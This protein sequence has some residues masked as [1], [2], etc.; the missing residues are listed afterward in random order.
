VTSNVDF[1]IHHAGLAWAEATSEG[2]AWLERLPGLVA[3]CAERWSL[4]I[5]EP[6][7]YAHAS[8]ALP[9]VL[10]DGRDAVLKISLP[11]R[12][13]AQ[14]AE[15]LAR[16][17]GNG[18]VELLEHDVERSALLL[19]RCRPGTDLTAVDQDEALDVAVELL[20]RLWVPAAAPFRS[21]RQEVEIWLEEL[22]LNYARAGAPF[23]DDLLRAAMFALSE[24]AG[25]Q[26]EHVLL[27]QDFH[28]L[29]VLRAERQPW[30]AIDPKPLV[31]ERAVG[32]T[33]LIRG[34][35]LGHSRRDVLHRLERLTSELGLD[36]ER[37]RWWAIGQSLAWA[38]ELDGPLA[39]HVEAAQWLFE[40]A[41]GRS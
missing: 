38:F 41:R 16:W 22:P 20:P 18:A 1:D 12:S 21:V 29:N 19:E 23:A 2:R 9:V 30:L 10:D 31:G 40:D 5:G 26:P 4:A 35:E 25:T 27:H 14:E 34:P 39:G 33:A 24:L 37:T 13:S 7:E 36:R 15:A 8:L 28:A 3:D 32:V 6:F 17:A 11:H